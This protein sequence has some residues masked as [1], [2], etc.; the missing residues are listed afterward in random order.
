LRIFS[1]ITVGTQ[2]GFSSRNA[3]AV[4]ETVLVIVKEAIQK[5]EPMQIANL[6]TFKV[7]DKAG[8]S[9]AI[10]PSAIG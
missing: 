7:R 2:D 8:G 1:R 9:D 10:P 4:V 6:G 5:R 3:A